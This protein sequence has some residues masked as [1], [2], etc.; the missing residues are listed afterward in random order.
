MPGYCTPSASPGDTQ[1][2]VGWDQVSYGYQV[3]YG[4]RGRPRTDCDQRMAIAADKGRT[5]PLS[6]ATSATTR[7]LHGGAQNRLRARRV[8]TVQLPNH[9]GSGAGEGQVVLYADAHAQ[10]ESKPTVGV[11]Y[12]NIYTVGAT[13][14]APQRPRAGWQA[15]RG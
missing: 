11:A 1:V 12:D 15:R 5:A 4:D 2:K 10:F 9:G 13:S 3:P 8:V 14:R 7:R 6:M